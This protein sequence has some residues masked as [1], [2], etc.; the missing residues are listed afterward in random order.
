MGFFNPDKKQVVSAATPDASLKLAAKQNAKLPWQM[1]SSLQQHSA[2]LQANDK[3][4][5]TAKEFKEAK[6]GVIFCSQFVSRNENSNNE[7]AANFHPRLEKDHANHLAVAN[8]SERGNVTGGLTELGRLGGEKALHLKTPQTAVLLLAIDALEC[9][10][11][12]DFVEGTK[13]DQPLFWTY[14]ELTE[15]HKKVAK[16]IVAHPNAQHLKADQLSR[17][18]IPEWISLHLPLLLDEE[19]AIA[20]YVPPAEDTEELQEAAMEAQLEK[21]MERNNERAY[22][23]H[24]FALNILKELLPNS[25]I[26]ED[27]EFLFTVATLGSLRKPLCEIH[28]P[29]L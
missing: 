5:D 6:M 9:L 17:E 14:L 4:P 23:T 25:V 2:L 20:T 7:Q 3:A 1:H 19:A 28:S 24:T 26:L 21:Q 12:E 15:L 8:E 18:S 16:L 22:G 10:K 13:A 29:R 11:N 27:K